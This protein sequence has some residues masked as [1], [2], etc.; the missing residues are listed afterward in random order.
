MRWWG[1]S[2]TRGGTAGAKGEEA[3]D[4]G[5]WLGVALTGGEGESAPVVQSVVV[6]GPAERAGLTAGDEV[7]AWNGS[8]LSKGRYGAMLKAARVGDEVTLHVFRRG[9]LCEVRATLVEAPRNTAWLAAVE[10]PTEAQLA[11]RAAWLGR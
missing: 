7:I 8:K 3:G 2:F 10:N 1:C 9:E 5:A 11:A 6:N 4:A